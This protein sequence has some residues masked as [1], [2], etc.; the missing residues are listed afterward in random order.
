MGVIAWYPNFLDVEAS[1]FGAESWPISVAW[2]EHT[3]EIR[4][5]LINPSS[6]PEWTHWD[7]AAEKLH[8]LDRERLARNGWSPADVTARIDDALRGGLAFSDAPDF[9]TTWLQRLYA[10]AG[11][12]MP[13]R[14]ESADDLLVGAIFHP[15][16]ALWQAQARLDRMKNELHT[17]CGGRHDAGYDVGFLVV[18]WRQAMGEPARMNHGI[19][20]VPE[21]TGT[22]SFLR[23]EQ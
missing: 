11:R 3:G 12:P 4:R 8:G 10:A 19:G 16:E 1:G 18:L 2:C 15:G 23:R 21:I 17:T 5:Y 14:I 9:D 22:G 6:V 7:P 13:F 20:P